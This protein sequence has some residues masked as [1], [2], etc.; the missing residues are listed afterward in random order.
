VEEQSRFQREVGERLRAIRAQQGL[1]LQEVEERSGGR[2]KAVVVGSYERGDRAV[3]VSKL[4]GLATFYDVPITEL[5]PEEGPPSSAAPARRVVLD[6]TT[7]QEG[8]QGP[9]GVV[10]RYARRIQVDRGDY[11]GR[12]LTLR[13]D[14]LQAMATVCGL[15]VEDLVVILD[16]A[17]VLRTIDD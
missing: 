9:V 8:D 7:L 15:G 10:A 12:V 16:D 11:N 17:H 6:L 13:R 1:T 5:L 2:W 14:D 4:A 3:S